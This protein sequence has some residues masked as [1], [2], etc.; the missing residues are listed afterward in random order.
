MKPEVLLNEAQRRLVVENRKL[1][2]PIIRDIHC[3][4]DNSMDSE[5]LEQMAMLHLC[6]AAAT[7]DESRGYSFST[8]ATSVIKNELYKDFRDT[9]RHN[10]TDTLSFSTQR[11]SD[12]EA[13]WSIYNLPDLTATYDRFESSYAIRQLLLK[14]GKSEKEDEKLYARIALEFMRGTKK[15]KI[16]EKLGISY[17]R[18][19]KCLSVIKE[20][21]KDFT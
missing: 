20:A 21:L 19:T 9:N 5:D 17:R 13:D 6:K 1:I 4:K 7:F 11:P 10:I 18:F 8:Y 14:W 12:E 16:P 2:F 3:E 15:M